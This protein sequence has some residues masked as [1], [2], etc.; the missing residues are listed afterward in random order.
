[1]ATEYCGLWVASKTSACN[2]QQLIVICNPMHFD[3]QLLCNTSEI[4]RRNAVDALSHSTLPSSSV[5]SYDCNYLDSWQW[6][7][8]DY[9]VLAR[10]LQALHSFGSFIYT[11]QF[12]LLHS[13]CAIYLRKGLFAGMMCIALAAYAIQSKRRPSPIMHT[14]HCREMLICQ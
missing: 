8:V 3:A 5:D 4:F 9:G 14:M 7:I 13:C 1:M 12:N 10:L 6:N 2:I 11:I